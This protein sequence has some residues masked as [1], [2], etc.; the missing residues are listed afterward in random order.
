NVSVR[1][2]SRKHG[3]GGI[4]RASFVRRRFEGGRCGEVA[5]NPDLG[6]ISAAA[7]AAR[8]E[9]C[10]EGGCGGHEACHVSPAAGTPKSEDPVGWASRRPRRYGCN[11]PLPVRY[12]AEA[13]G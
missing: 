10:G 11:R 9:L 3:R 6:G 1:H 7:F 13:D 8:Q 4:C 2:V 12:V 5:W